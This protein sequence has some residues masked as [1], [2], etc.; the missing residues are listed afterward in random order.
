M[1]SRL[2]I[3]SKLLVC[4]A[5]LSVATLIVAVSGFR[6]VYSYRQL[7]RTISLRA[8][9]LPL[10]GDL[11]R[12][13]SDLRVTLSRARQVTSLT[14]DG[15][16]T[17]IDIVVLRH[18]FRT[19][20]DAVEGKLQQYR[21]QLET[22]LPSDPR[23][24]DRSHERKT[25]DAIERS[26]KELASSKDQPDW[27]LDP[28]RVMSLSAQADEVY[29]LSASLPQELHQ[30]MHDFAKEIRIEYRTWIVA[31]WVST[32]LAGGL[33]CA[34]FVL[35]YTWIVAPLQV[36]I[37]GSRRIAQR[38]DFDHRIFLKSRDEMAELASAL[39]EMTAR[40]QEIRR[41]LDDQVKQRT[42]EVVRSEQLASVGFLAAGV[43]HE[44]NNPLASIAWCAESLESRLY[45]ILHDDLTKPTE[46]QS[47]EIAVLRK[48]LTRI[49]D[50]AFRCKGI[51]DGL[52]D[53]S[54][55]GDVEKQAT[56]L[57]ELIEGVIEMVR[58]LGKYR[59]KQV[60][61]TSE[62]RV[63]CP[64][65]AQEFK[66]VMLNLIT[67]GLDSLDPGGIVHVTLKKSGNSAEI[68]VRDNGCGMSPEVLEH[69]FEPFFTR[70][71]DGQG[72][73]LGLSITYRIVMDHGGSLQPASDGP[74]KGSRMRLLLPL[75]AKDKA[76]HERDHEK[77]QAA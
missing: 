15:E 3:K 74:G 47:A 46:Q 27:I 57:G 32:L 11:S 75:D 37:D 73:G 68:L 42:K 19:K 20:L 2:S 10:A 28:V 35:S 6:G 38:D 8:S 43:A 48:Y 56:D 24:G 40:F 52:L 13:L 18:E 30:R 16:A 14:L 1:F 63:A 4:V 39:N 50:E 33:L 49:Q 55:L 76:T 41:D 23:F 25:I 72:T 59:E 71:R 44:I 45:D 77:R 70:R 67:N 7:A 26:L 9:E 5:L 66:Q 69:L 22:E 61:F 54:R 17:E 36:L 64:V 62:G 51:T 60:E 34:M 58:H 29:E 53:F 31:T 12:T 21:A 65:N